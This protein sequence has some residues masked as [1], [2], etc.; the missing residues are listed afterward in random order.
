VNIEEF[1]Q[2]I[3]LKVWCWRTAGQLNLWLVLSVIILLTQFPIPVVRVDV[4]LKL[5]AIQ[6]DFQAA[7]ECGFVVEKSPI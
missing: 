7:S 3:L 5:N 2:N 4:S 6:T 1:S